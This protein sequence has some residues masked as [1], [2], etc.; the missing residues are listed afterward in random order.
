LILALT[1]SPTMFIDGK[2]FAIDLEKQQT[3]FENKI[4]VEQNDL[5]QK[6]KH[7]FIILTEFVSIDI[8]DKKKNSELQNVQHTVVDLNEKVSVS[9]ISVDD[10]VI[11]MIKGNDERKT[12][13]ERIFDR[14]KL[15]RIVFDSSIHS[16]EDDITLS[17]LTNEYQQEQSYSNLELEIDQS[18]S[19]SLIDFSISENNFDTLYESVDE[20]NDQL[21]VTTNSL[22]SVNNPLFM[23]LVLPLAG[24]ILV[25]TENEKLNFNDLKRVFCFVFITILISSAV[26][27]PLSISSAY[28]GVA[29]AEEFSIDNQTSSDVIPIDTINSEST[30]PVEPVNATSVEPVNA[31]SVE[32]VNATSVEPAEPVEA[33]L[34]T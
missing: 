26:I 29:Y 6:P 1:T 22:S 32:P 11:I 5:I 14:A 15:N 12:I 28:W 17:S 13:M 16:I 10:S 9:D 24:F 19:T 27:T 33:I 21:I 20:I 8:D 34:T 23:L 25:R 31:T 18:L 30:E 2:A 7:N 4:I 3:I